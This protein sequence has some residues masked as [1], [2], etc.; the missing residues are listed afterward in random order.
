MEPYFFF[1]CIPDEYSSDI[2]LRNISAILE[3][4]SLLSFEK[5]L[6]IAKIL[7]KLESTL[8]IGDAL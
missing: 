4:N 3:D 1:S 6:F 2:A 5:I 7:Q 8:D